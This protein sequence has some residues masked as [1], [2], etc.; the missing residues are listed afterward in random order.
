MIRTINSTLFAGLI[1]AAVNVLIAQTTQAQERF[2]PKDILER[3]D[4]NKNGL[5]EGSEISGRAREHINR[6]AERAGLD[7]TKPLAIKTLLHSMG[8][9]D[10]DRDSD[11]GRGYDRGRDDRDRSRSYGSKKSEP[12]VPGFGVEDDLPPPP[13]FDIPADSPLASTL[14][15][16]DRYDAKVIEYVEQQ[17]LRRY[18]RN[19]NDILESEEWK[20]VR[21]SSDPNESDLNKDRRLTKVELCERIAKRWSKGSDQGSSRGGSSRGGESSSGSSGST[22]SGGSDSSDKVKR[23]VDGVIKQYDKNKNGLLE[24][25]E[26]EGMRG[27]P[28]SADRNRDRVITRE[29]LYFKLSGGKSSS[30][31]SSSSTSSSSGS[32]EKKPDSRYSKYSRYRRDDDR[33]DDRDDDRGSEGKSYRFRT[34]ADRL[35][36]GLPSWFEDADEDGD[37]QVKMGEYSSSWTDEKVAE[38]NKYDQN[39]DGLI[40]PNEAL[41]GEKSSR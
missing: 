20:D 27:D 6:A 34:V 18:D 26:W 32:S 8:N 37:G 12:L 39:G 31:G 1:F 3:M 35:P 14:P 33:R 22:S 30:S 36:R 5:L 29:E 11:R 19:G 4:A 9:R 16:K 24:K 13:G 2:D 17:I 10:D 15:L 40:T 23:Y 21:W 38:F 7:P 25:D 28:A 41:S